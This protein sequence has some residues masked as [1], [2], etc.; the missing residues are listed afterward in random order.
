MRILV[1]EDDP[2]LNNQIKQSLEDSGYSVDTASDGEEGHFLGDTEPYDAV[3]LDLGLPK[4]DGITVLEK[5]RK[6]KKF[7]SFDSYSKRS[8]E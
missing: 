7:S 5:W 8:V 6:K 2:N 3:V 1:I 4:V